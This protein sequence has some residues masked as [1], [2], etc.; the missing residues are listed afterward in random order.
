MTVQVLLE[1]SQHHCVLQ[2][3]QVASV[4][5]LPLQLAPK[6]KFKHRGTL[7][8]FI[9][10]SHVS[11]VTQHGPHSCAL[12]LVS[13]TAGQHSRRRCPTLLRCWHVPPPGEDCSGQNPTGSLV[14]IQPACK[15]CCRTASS[16]Q[17][18]LPFATNESGCFLA[19]PCPRPLLSLPL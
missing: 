17:Q 10:I 13:L 4:I 1:P 16:C 9:L 12:L 8:L 19:P 7:A 11:S 2:A 15:A 14:M 3:C 5:S 18:Q 6:F